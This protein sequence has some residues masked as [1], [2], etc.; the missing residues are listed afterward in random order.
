MT[1]LTPRRFFFPVT[2]SSSVGGSVGSSLPTADSTWVA[3]SGGGAVLCSDP[4]A[5]FSAGSCSVLSSACVSVLS[6][7]CASVRSSACA[8]SGSELS[9]QLLVAVPSALPSSTG[10]PPS[11]SSEPGL[12]SPRTRFP[13][14]VGHCSDVA[15]AGYYLPAGLPA[16]MRAP[17]SSLSVTHERRGRLCLVWTASGEDQDSARSRPR[18]CTIAPVCSG[19]RPVLSTRP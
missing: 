1:A 13:P 15:P 3:S 11:C 10:A 2:G 19:A 17:T 8:T 6:S 7:A 18:W 5:A 12:C 9:P 14:Q 4:A 16:R